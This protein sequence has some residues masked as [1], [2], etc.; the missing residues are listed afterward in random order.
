MLERFFTE[1]S[2]KRSANTQRNA[3]GGARLRQHRPRPILQRA[4]KLDL[5]PAKTKLIEIYLAK[6]MVVTR[7]L[8]MDVSCR[9]RPVLRQKQRG[10]PSLSLTTRVCRSTIRALAEQ[11]GPMRS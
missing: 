6:A 7:D 1:T 3:D 4:R 10:Q 9:Q 5:A 8:V 11:P 2:P